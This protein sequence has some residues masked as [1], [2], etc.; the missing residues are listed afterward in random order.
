MKHPLGSGIINGAL[1]GAMWGLVFLAP[2]V[3]KDC[4]PL[5]VCIGRYVAYGL[6]SVVL[7]APGWRA[8]RGHISLAEWRALAWLSLAGNLVYFV[9]VVMAVQ[10]AGGAATSLIVGMVPVVVALA[11]SRLPDATPLRQLLL[12]LALSVAGVGLIAYQSL[13]HAG[14]SQPLVTRCLGLACAFGALLSW[15]GYSIGNSRWLA[16][17]SDLSGHQWSLLTGLVTGAEACLLIPVLAVTAGDQWLQPRSGWT[18]Y[19]GVSAAIALLAS[20][21]G[22][23]CWNRASKQLPLALSGQMVVFETLFALLYTFVWH[24]R[25]P[26]LVE[27]VAMLCLLSGVWLAARTHGTLPAAAELVDEA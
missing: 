17:R 7:L 14:A 15:S 3:L 4:P 18:S 25:G 20:V 13:A 5:Q 10:M 6:L 22:N 24:Q 1:A 16:R 8:L 23:A 11:S 27:V 19:L 12:P 21:V 9:L 26:S 2:V